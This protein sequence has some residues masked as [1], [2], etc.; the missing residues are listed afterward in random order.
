MIRID[1]QGN[2]KKIIK[3]TVISLLITLILLMVFSILLTY[4]KMKESVIPTVTIIITGVSI[5]IGGSLTTANI[6]KNGM[7]TGGS[8]GLIYMLI[9]YL[10]SSIITGDFSL[11][12]YSIVMIIASALAGGIGG[13]I[14]VNIKQ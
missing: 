12:I 7:M 5:M 3:G 9:L 1:E 8:V 10:V 11:N 2:V 14:G 13:I 6:S 4:T